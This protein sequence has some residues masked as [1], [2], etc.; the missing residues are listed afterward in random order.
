MCAGKRLRQLCTHEPEVSESE[1]ADMGFVLARSCD[2]CTH[3]SEFSESEVADMGWVLARS[4][5]SCTHEPWFCGLKFGDE[6]GLGDKFQL[7]NTFC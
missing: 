1:L 6:V 3:E 7:G 2:S 5:D 4:C